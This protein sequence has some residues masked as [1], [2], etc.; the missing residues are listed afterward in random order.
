M[1]KKKTIVFRNRRF[2]VEISS[3]S[4]KDLEKEKKERKMEK[5]RKPRQGVVVAFYG[6]PE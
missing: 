6:T 5:E 2:K 1:Q 4:A 3:N